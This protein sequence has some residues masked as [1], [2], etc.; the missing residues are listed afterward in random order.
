VRYD[1]RAQAGDY[2][3]ARRALAS[4]F[5]LSASPRRF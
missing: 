2:E 1:G 3:P 4:T 5:T